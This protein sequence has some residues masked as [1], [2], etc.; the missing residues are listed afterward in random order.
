ML[1]FFPRGV[2]DENLNL[3]ESF[4]E[5]FPSYSYSYNTTRTYAI[6]KDLYDIDLRGRLLNFISNFLSNRFFNINKN[7]GSH[8]G[9][10][11]P[12]LCF[13]SKLNMENIEF[14]LQRGLNKVE[15]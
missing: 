3:I 13:I 2:L 12:L 1:S 15:T 5:G 11:Y 4:S 9:V 6:M 7:R 8:K 10:F 14:R